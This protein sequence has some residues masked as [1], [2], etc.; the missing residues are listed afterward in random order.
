MHA[1]TIPTMRAAPRSAPVQWLIAIN[2][3][4]MRAT[5][6]LAATLLVAETLVLLCGVVARYVLHMPLL[7]SDELATSMFLWLSMLGAVL[8]LHRGEHMRLTAFVNRLAPAR[9]A[10]VEALS[11]T[12][13]CAF[14]AV[15]LSPAAEH[16]HE[17]MQITTPS[18]ELP[19]GFRA[20][21]LPIGLG[22][23]LLTAVTRICQ[24]LTWKQLTSVMLTLAVVVVV[25]IASRPMLLAMGN[26]NLVVFFV[27]GVGLCVIGGVPIAFAFGVCTMAYLMSATSMPALVV[28]SRMDEGMSSLVLLSVPLFILLGALLEFTGLARTLIDFMASLIG[29]VRGGL[30]YVLLGGMFLVSGIS[31]SKTADM[32][33]VAPALFPEM[34]KRGAKPEDLVAL[35]SSSGAMTETIPPSLVLITIGAACGVSIAALFTGGV[36]P[37]LVATAAITAVCWYKTRGDSTSDVPRAS[38]RRIATTFAWAVPALA[39]PLLIRA[40]VIE[41]VATA[42]EVATIGV[43]YTVVVGLLLNIFLRQMNFKRL[44]PLLVDTAALSGAIMFIIALA[45]AMAWALTQSGFSRA[46]VTAMQS[47]PGGAIGFMLVSIVAFVVLGSVLEGIP[48]I[49]LFGPLLFPAA[50]ALG[51]HD[52]HY[53]MVVILAMGVGLFAPPLGVGFYAACAIGKVSPDA[54]VD[55]VWPYLGALILALLVVAAFPWLSIGLLK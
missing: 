46:L 2:G 23:M 37:A 40:A 39:L 22:L 36:V 6:W 14:V 55:R 9:R 44:Y 24:Q 8:A 1:N 28:V 20:A 48:A 17:Q 27:L 35:L 30:Q 34:K 42:T 4:A 5:A 31:G 51:I 32:A 18:L 52:V 50:R 10:W 38:P 12:I 47:L 3:W 26:F 41:G 33:A 53:A 49:V 7:W 11:T 29:H 19:D 43:A 21:A 13:V 15:V 25:L 54:V 16:A 45:G